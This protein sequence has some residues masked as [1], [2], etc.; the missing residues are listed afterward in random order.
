MQRRQHRYTVELRVWDD[1]LDPDVI[2]RET[3]LQP[4]QTRRRG[5]KRG[6]RIDSEGLWA[7]DG[8]YSQDWDSL[9]D[10]LSFLLDRLRGYEEFFQRYAAKYDVVWWCGHFQS[11]FDGGP[12]LSHELLE[13]LTF[14][15]ASLFIDNYFSRDPDDSA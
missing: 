4:C 11:A 10:G 1:D 14:F 13:R 5:L 15:G 6:E 2:T 7:F 3:G 9:S 12:T 8:G